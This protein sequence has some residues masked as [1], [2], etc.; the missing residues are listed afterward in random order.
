MRPELNGRGK[1]GEQRRCSRGRRPGP[2]PGGVARKFTSEV[3]VY[4]V[5]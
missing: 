5:R 3:T 4:L 2:V 1:A